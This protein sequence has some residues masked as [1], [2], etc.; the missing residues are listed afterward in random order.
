MK[1]ILTLAAIVLSC[2][3]MQAD[4]HFL[5][6]RQTDGT[7]YSLPLAALNMQFHD[8][9][10]QATSGQE[11]LTLDLVTLQ[12][13]YFA[14]APTGIQAVTPIDSRFTTVYDLQGRPTHLGAKASE[15]G[16][17]EPGIYIIKEGQKARKEIVR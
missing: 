9:Q 6:F 11:A 14:S 4:E 2:S 12:S 1:K 16:G 8:G 5:T 3:S 17:A 10:M 13:M 15:R 7:E